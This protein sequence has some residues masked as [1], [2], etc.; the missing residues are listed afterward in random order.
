MTAK[1]AIAAATVRAV[2][3]TQYD[4]ELLDAHYITGDGR[5]NENIGLTAVHHVF[6]SEHNRMV[7][8]IKEVVLQSGDLDFLNEWLLGAELTESP[9]EGASLSWDGERLFQAARF[10]TEMQY[11]HLV[12]EEFARKIQPDIDVFMV[13][14]DAELNPVIFSEF[15]N[16]VYRFGHSMLNETVDRINPDGTRDDMSLFDAFLNPLAFGSDDG[17]SRRRRR[18]R[19]SAA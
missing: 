18:V 9:A 14:P 7:E 19:S 3:Q 4:D 8:H 13:Q 10:S 6:H 5:G 15:A 1:S 2:R 12:F 11:Q 16:V 17:R